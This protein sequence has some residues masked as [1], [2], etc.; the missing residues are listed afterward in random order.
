VEIAPN[1]GLADGI[2]D[3]VSSGS[4]LF[5]NNLK[6]VEVMLKS[7]AVLAISPEISEE[8]KAILEKLQFRFKSVLNART[9]KYILLNAPNE[10]LDNIIKLLPGMRSPTV[11]PLAEKG[12]SSIHTVIN[13]ERFWEVIDELKNNGAEGILVAPIEKMVL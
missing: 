8:R 11:L 5:K 1:I 12:W 9:S 10:N 2:C 6:E 7:E 13:E 3:I 4:T